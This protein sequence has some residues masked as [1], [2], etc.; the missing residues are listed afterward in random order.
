VTNSK[1][2]QLLNYF[3]ALVWLINGLFCK[4]FNL[5]P[6]HQQIVSEILGNEQSRLYTIL[7]GISES[8]MAVW[9]LSGLYTRINAITQIVVI[10]VMN[11][12]EFI[13]V[14]DLLLWGRINAVFA[15]LF[16]VLIYYN[17]FLLN[18]NITQTAR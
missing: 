15:F 7:I 1:K 11:T 6:R 16:I 8:L 10:A 12:L 14:P 2:H 13:L 17:E 9:I 4:V 18:K 3:I 5:V